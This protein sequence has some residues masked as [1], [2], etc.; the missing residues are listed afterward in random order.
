MRL[1]GAV[2][3]VDAI[4]CNPSLTKI[5]SSIDRPLQRVSRKLVIAQEKF[6]PLTDPEKTLFVLV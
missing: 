4:S 1:F 2:G 5:I 6:F 3:K